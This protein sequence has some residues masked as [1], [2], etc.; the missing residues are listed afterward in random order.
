MHWRKVLARSFGRHAW[1]SLE[2][3]VASTFYRYCGSSR[4]A[5]AQALTRLAG[6]LKTLE[7]MAGSEGSL[8]VQTLVDGM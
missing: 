7:S 3:V 4:C 8:S 2:R 1:L 6:F 5:I